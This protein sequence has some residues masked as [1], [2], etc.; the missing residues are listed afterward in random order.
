MTHSKIDEKVLLPV[1]ELLPTRRVELTT[2]GRHLAEGR[3]DLSILRIAAAGDAAGP[4]VI[5]S[6]AYDQFV[7][8]AVEPHTSGWSR[9]SREQ[10]SFFGI[11][12]V[13]GNT[14]GTLICGLF[15]AFVEALD[16]A[17]DAGSSLTA[18][19]WE[20]M[21]AGP[22]AMLRYYAGSPAATSSLG[23][24]VPSLPRTS[25]PGGE[26]TV[27]WEIG[28]RLFFTLTQCITVALSCFASEYAAGNT[29]QS[30][31]ALNLAT[32]LMRASAMSMR[33]ASDFPATHYHADVRPSMRPPHVDPGFSGVMGR[34]HQILVSLLRRLRPIFSTLDRDTAAFDELRAATRGLFTAH[35]LVCSK[36]G[37]DD[38]PSLL[39]DSRSTHNPAVT[40]STVTRRLS[41]R[42]LSLLGSPAA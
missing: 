6:N 26:P 42:R 36:F 24:P 3:F 23:F 17:R 30:V 8:P 15:L 10:D 32:I 41:Q 16:H 2:V 27:Q 21:L 12:R 25:V 34:D 1:P 38:K 37:G 18:A 5:I 40:A 28:H 19:E 22:A 39:M 35:E 31:L 14:A 11:I 20:Q 33:F 29:D 9:Q 7:R 13:D 4:R